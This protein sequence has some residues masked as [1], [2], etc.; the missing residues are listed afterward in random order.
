MKI[1]SAKRAE[2]GYTFYGAGSER[3]NSFVV[4]PKDMIDEKTTD[5]VDKPWG[6]AVAFGD[7]AELINSL[8]EKGVSVFKLDE[9]RV[10]TNHL[11][12]SDGTTH[13]QWEIV[14]ETLL[15]KGFAK[16]LE[17]FK[18]KGTSSAKSLDAA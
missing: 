2:P 8:Y 7:V 3:D 1:S 5:N 17:K 6:R 15:M 13:E 11:E 4:V 18:G 12:R 16:A 10:R 14:I 9:G